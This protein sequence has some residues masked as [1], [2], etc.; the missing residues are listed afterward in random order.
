[1]TVVLR[2]LRTSLIPR[3][4]FGSTLTAT[5]IVMLMP[6]PVAG[7]LVASAPAGGL[8]RLLLV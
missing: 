1:M 2:T 4:A 8:P 7:A 5:I 6:L 3:A